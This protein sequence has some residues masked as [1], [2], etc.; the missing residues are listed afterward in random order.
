MDSAVLGLRLLHGE[1]ISTAIYTRGCHIEVF[2]LL[3]L[4][5][6]C[7]VCD[8]CHHRRPLLLTVAPVNCAE[9]L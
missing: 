3:L 7:H 8:Q 1:S 4:L 9:G 5:K 6:R 2:T